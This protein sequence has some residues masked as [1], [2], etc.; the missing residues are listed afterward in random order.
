MC[1]RTCVCKCDF[2]CVCESSAARQLHVGF[3]CCHLVEPRR[4][5]PQRRDVLPRRHDPRRRARG[6]FFE[7]FPKVVNIFKKKRPKSKKKCRPNEV[8][9]QAAMSPT[10]A[11]RP[12]TSVRTAVRRSPEADIWGCS[13]DP[14]YLC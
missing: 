11:T 7:I 12:K 6:K 14:R 10:S 4:H 2:V 1:L 8:K 5:D 9:R 3:I 13:P